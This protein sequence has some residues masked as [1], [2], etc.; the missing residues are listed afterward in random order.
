MPD[1]PQGFACEFPPTSQTIKAKR[2]QEASNGEGL[3]EQSG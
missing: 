3:K 2:G 1:F